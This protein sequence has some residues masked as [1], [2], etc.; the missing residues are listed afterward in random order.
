[1]LFFFTFQIAIAFPDDGAWKR[2][3]K[4]LHHFP[5][6]IPCLCYS[7]TMMCS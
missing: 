3:H 4:Q 5:T 6:V 7:D 1:M 2:F